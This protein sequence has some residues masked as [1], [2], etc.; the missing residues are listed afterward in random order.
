MV[1]E[2]LH[3]VDTA[4]IQRPQVHGTHTKDMAVLHETV[5]PDLPGLADINAVE[6]YLAS[7]GYGIHGMTDLEGNM[8]WAYGLGDA[9]FWQAGGVNE[10][11]V[12]IEQVSDI[13]AFVAAKSMT[14]PAA[15]AAWAKRTAQ[16]HAT[17]SLLAAWHNVDPTHHVLEYSQGLTPGV[18]SHWDVSQHFPASEGHTDCWPVTKGGYYPILQ[19]IQIARDLAKTG[20]RF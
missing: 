16:L 12:G 20:V 7:I 15:A 17:A 4:A 6:G 19:V 14:V 2:R 1:T 5:S 9:V 11:A 13:P 10:R 3:Y 18:T 8:A